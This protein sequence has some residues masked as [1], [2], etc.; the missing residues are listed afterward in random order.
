MELSTLQEG[1]FILIDKEKHW[2]SFDVVKKI[3]SALRIKKIGHAGTLDPLATGLLILAT[4]KYTK[5]IEQVQTQE[6]TYTGVIC[7]GKST[8]SYD[9]ETE[10]VERGGT[11]HLT[12]GDVLIAIKEGFLGEVEQR[13]P[14]HS[15]V[16]VDGVR[17]YQKARLNKKVEIKTR[18]VL[19][20]EFQL[21]KWENPFLHFKIRCSKGTY[22]RSIANDIGEK[23]GVGGYLHELRRTGI[24]D[25]KVEDAKMVKEFLQ[26]MGLEK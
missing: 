17:A 9:L 22:I 7:L 26:E 13:P 15:A 18:K 3:R 25:H 2:T 1:A 23:L 24:G 12:Q 6:K 14:D 4:G 16:K 21:L 20:H 5:R 10:V 19:I 8:P 11:E